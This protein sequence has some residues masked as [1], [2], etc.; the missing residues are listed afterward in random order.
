V[1]DVLPYV[2][3]LG[4]NILYLPPVH[5]IGAT[6]RK[7]KNNAVSAKPGDTGSPWA[8]GAKE[9]GHKAL[10]PELGSFADFDALVKAAKS[11]GIEIALDIAFQCSP[12]H[13]YVKSHPEWFRWRPDG[14]V[15][16]AENPPKK[17]QD[18]YPF[19]FESAAW[20]SLWEELESV[21]EFWIGH[22]VTVFR[23]DNPHTKP[24][25]FWEWCIRQLKQ[26]HPEVIFLSEAFTRPRIMHK[27][28]KLGFSQSYTYFAWRNTKQELT[29]YFTELSQH[30]SREYFRPNVWPN[31]PDI[32]HET[33]QHGGRPA[34]IVRAVL[35]A[36]L[37]ANYGMYGPAYELQERTP[38]EPGSEEYLN[39]EKYEIKDWDLER[40]D[41][42]APLISRLNAIRNENAALQSD[43]SLKF[44]PIDNDQMIAYSKDDILVVVNLD[45]NHPQSGWI[46]FGPCTVHDLLAGGHYTWSGA[47][48]YIELSPHTLPAHVFKVTRP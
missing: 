39:S 36:T 3:K 44:H 31:T 22:G 34:F 47:R 41:S 43:W 5:P 2:E 21:F 37:A 11:R 48:N 9:G 29:E 6:A 33:L 25:E 18:I 27:L 20:K 38:R 8:I 4:F 10:H 32:L 7:G 24:F 40:A 35:A 16:Y 17:Y 42:L 14:T 45:V 28:S 15:Q 13:P 12:D 46:D 19:E 1:I 23:V 30:E 26:K